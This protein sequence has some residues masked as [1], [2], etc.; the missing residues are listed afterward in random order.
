MDAQTGFSR[1]K[2]LGPSSGS[3]SP[4]ASDAIDPEV[5]LPKVSDH[6]LLRLI[7]RGSYGE[8]WLA[9]NVTGEYRAVKIVRRRSFDHARPFDREFSG[10][11]KFEPISRSHESQLAILHVGRNDGE[12]YFYYVLELADDENGLE[13]Q[14][15][16]RYSPRT[17]KNEIRRRGRLDIDDCIS[18]GERLAVALKHLHQHGLVHRDIKP[19]NIVFVGGVPKLADIG[20]VT[21]VDAS[22]SFVGTEGFIPPEGPGS[23]QAD[24]Y[25]LGKVLYEMSTGQDRHE[26]PDLPS[27]VQDLPNAARLLEINAIILKACQNDPRDRY[28]SADE[29]LK[30]LVLLKDGRSVRQSRTLRRRIRWTI[31]AA[32]VGGVG[33]TVAAMWSSPHLPIAAAVG[34]AIAGG[35]L[36]ANRRRP[37]MPWIS[38]ERPNAG[39]RAQEH[40]SHSIAV[41]PFEV[42][43]T[44][45]VEPWLGAEMADEIAKVLTRVPGLRVLPRSTSFT[46]KRAPDRSKMISALGLGFVLEGRVRRTGETL[47][48]VLEVVDGK[49]QFVVWSE[50]YSRPVRDL[51]VVQTDV[52]EQ[53]AQ[54]L[55]IPLT[56]TARQRIARRP[57][58][59]L[60]AYDLYLQGRGWWNRR[61][62]ADLLKAVEYFNRAIEK[63]PDY[64]L[65]YA[66]VADAYNYI[67][68]GFG[69][70]AP[71]QVRSKAS[72]AI[73]KALEL[74]DSL[75]EVRAAYAC[76]K[77]VFEWDAD[78]AHREF[79]CAIR[80]NPEY[81]TAHHL[82]VLPLILMGKADEAVAA[83]R[84]ALQ[85]DPLSVNLQH[86]LGFLL[87][88]ARRFKEAISELRNTLELDPGYSLAR[89]SLAEAFLQERMF[90]EFAHER[91]AFFDSR[92]DGRG[93][94]ERL[95][96]A[97]S[98]SGWQGCQQA[99]LKCLLAQWERGGAP[100]LMGF[101]IAKAHASL[102]DTE[103]AIEW[104][105]TLSRLRVA[106]LAWAKTDPA[107]DPLRRDP[108]FVRLLE[109]MDART[110]FGTGSL[111]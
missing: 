31:D 46:I 1:L 74:D 70:L 107:L 98:E 76:Y 85:L 32:V 81:A 3:R 52:A 95:R 27:D 63:D 99:Y 34:L 68:Y 106:I 8:V 33:G 9:R 44:E 45:S 51:F 21:S 58:A 29:M 109:N 77:A 20:L 54:V 89:L 82:S 50:R 47:T 5:S 62:P 28:Q 30:D 43:D 111:D 6:T 37:A 48:L 2:L 42:E 101:E 96:C 79:E 88:Q 61:S 105:E 25:S 64:A 71:A 23:P 53:L 67:A 7:G 10:I 87:L 55:G 90:D 35:V 59:N 104:L 92:P 72:D 86:V 97:Y 41:L 15:P 38:S 4:D 11:Q 66:G 60:E 94:A 57:T 56:D 103:R 24:L 108:R 49:D 19:S 18:I 22:R 65:A 16:A 75:S 93:T 78:G 84:Q 69:A 36:A 14:D 110:P 26:F 80:F 17:L 102:G 100:L 39:E 73:T 13:C 40:R 12:G 91:V 83:A